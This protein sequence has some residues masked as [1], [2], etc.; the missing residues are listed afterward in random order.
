MNSRIPD[1]V[2]DNWSAGGPS[3]GKMKRVVFGTNSDR[4]RHQG[5]LIHFFQEVDKGYPA[6]SGVFPGSVDRVSQCIASPIRP[7][8]RR[9]MFSSFPSK[10]SAS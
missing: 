1:H 8:A 9:P 6:A 5:Y 10:F 3:V 4:E 2:L 7:A